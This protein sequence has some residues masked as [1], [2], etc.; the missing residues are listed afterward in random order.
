MASRGQQSRGWGW[1]RWL[2]ISPLF[3]VQHVFCNEPSW[4]P[5][6]SGLGNNQ[7]CRLG[8]VTVE[9]KL[10]GWVVQKGESQG[11]WLC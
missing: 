11:A 6:L 5:E 4:S 10:L 9:T 7:A 2:K 1:K 8:L 3:H